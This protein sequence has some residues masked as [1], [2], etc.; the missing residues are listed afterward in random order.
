MFYIQMQRY[1]KISS[2]ITCTPLVSHTCSPKGFI[3]AEK[4]WDDLKLGKQRCSFVVYT[5]I[6]KPIP[7]IFSSFILIGASKEKNKC[8]SCH[9][10]DLED[11]IIS[12]ALVYLFDHKT[13]SNTYV[14]TEH[15]DRDSTSHATLGHPNALTRV[16]WFPF[17]P[18]L[19]FVVIEYDLM[20]LAV[21]MKI[22]K[23]KMEIFKCTEWLTSYEGKYLWDSYF[24]FS[25]GD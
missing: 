25:I 14:S 17:D 3:S 10:D 19:F 5:Y 9:C 18:S 2:R 12:C 1:D 15:I 8:V 24:S 22:L 20:I 7:A 13:L 21:V 11:C 23:S 6:R 4:L 16:H